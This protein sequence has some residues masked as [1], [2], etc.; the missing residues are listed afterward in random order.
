M[1]VTSQVGEVQLG[2]STQGARD[3]R[4]WTAKAVRQPGCGR[5]RT[6]MIGIFAWLA[7]MVVIAT[8]LFKWEVV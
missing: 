2:A 4:R 1:S 3:R 7:I 5:R 8:R 6:D